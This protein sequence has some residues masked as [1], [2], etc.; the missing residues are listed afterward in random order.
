[1]VS[2]GKYP[3]ISMKQ[4]KARRREYMDMLEDGVNPSKHKQVQKVKLATE[5]DFRTVALDWHTKHYQSN[6]ARHNKLI[7]LRLEKYIFPHFRK[8]T[9]KRHRS[10]YAF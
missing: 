5:K 7:L 2:L 8:N 9:F 3:Q 6:N 1:M 4:A 10:T